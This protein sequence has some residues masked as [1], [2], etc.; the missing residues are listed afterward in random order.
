MSNDQNPYRAST[1]GYATNVQYGAEPARSAP[2][3]LPAAANGAAAGALIKDTTT[4]GFPAEKII[5]AARERKDAL[6]AMSTHGRS[7][8]NRF[9][10]GSVTDRVVRHGGDPVLVI[11]AQE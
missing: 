5:D 6:V 4:A 3:S 1:G 8:V 7:G 9:V 11:R 10:M 2:G